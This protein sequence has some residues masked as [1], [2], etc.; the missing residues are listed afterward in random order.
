MNSGEAEHLR[1]LFTTKH[2]DVS[3]VC[4]GYRKLDNCEHVTGLR[5]FGHVLRRDSGDIR[6]RM[7]QTGGKRE[8]AEERIQ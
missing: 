7:S 2:R 3:S 6:Q 4:V 8:T 5:W 1:Q